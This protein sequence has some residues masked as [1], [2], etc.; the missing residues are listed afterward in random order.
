MCEVLYLFLMETP[1]ADH[2]S[3]I[4]ICRNSFWP[5]LVHGF[6]HVNQMGVWTFL[7]FHGRV[8]GLYSNGLANPLLRAFVPKT[9]SQLSLLGEDYFL[10]LWKD[11]IFENSYPPHTHTCRETSMPKCATQFTYLFESVH[12]LGRWTHRSVGLPCCNHTSTSWYHTSGF[13]KPRSHWGYRQFF[14]R[15]QTAKILAGCIF[16]LWIATGLTKKSV[17]TDPE[18]KTIHAPVL[19]SS[20]SSLL[21]KWKRHWTSGAAEQNDGTSASVIYLTKQK[22]NNFLST[23]QANGKLTGISRQHTSRRMDR[24]AFQQTTGRSSFLRGHLRPLTIPP[25]PHSDCDNQSKPHLPTRTS[26]G[27]QRETP[28][29]TYGYF[30]STHR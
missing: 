1:N 3:K 19:L 13:L 17:N 9:W 26:A 4:N 27:K 15:T 2:S 16:S 7:T 28:G 23:R 8:T 14:V 6:L 22:F 10:S 21:W 30:S 5:K 24:I 12:G 29:C 20:K 18:Q 25:V 11:I